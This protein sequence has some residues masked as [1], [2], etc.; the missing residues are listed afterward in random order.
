MPLVGMMRPSVQIEGKNSDHKL[1]VTP[2][3][4]RDMIL[5]EDWLCQHNAQIKFNPAVLIVNS[6]RR[7]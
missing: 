5:I 6:V 4:C 2:D 1:Y 3:I 7:P